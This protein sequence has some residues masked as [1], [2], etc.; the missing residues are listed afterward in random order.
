M[1]LV[2]KSKTYFL[3]VVGFVCLFVFETGSQI[4]EASLELAI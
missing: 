4:A 1:V 2:F 3:V